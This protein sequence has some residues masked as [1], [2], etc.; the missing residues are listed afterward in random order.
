MTI[1][2]VFKQSHVEDLHHLVLKSPARLER[3]RAG[4]FE[5]PL[6]C[7]LPTTISVGAP[8]VMMTAGAPLLQLELDNA[9]AVYE[10]LEALTDV[11]ARDPRL[12]VYLTHVV[13]PDYCRTR[14]P[15][16]ADEA[17]ARSSIVDH[18]FLKGRGLASLRRNAL[19]RL[20]WAA[21]LTKEPWRNHAFASFV[22]SDPYAYLRVLFSNQDIYQC[23][24]ERRYGASLNVLIPALEAIRRSPQRATSEF[25]TELTKELNLLASYRELGVL[26]PAAMLE[27]V[28]LI[29][30]RIEGQP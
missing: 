27:T 30:Q 14:W 5:A 22:Q 13:F 9:I 25:A 23:L 2:R 29:A 8:P 10:W 18:W 7:T 4:E 24:L 28:L 20:W 11:Q 6:S 12:W 19:A 21:R 16:P 17:K 1:L 26:A 3:Y 15:I